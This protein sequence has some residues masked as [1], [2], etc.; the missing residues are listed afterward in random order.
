MKKLNSKILIVAAAMLLVA[1][2]GKSEK[3]EEVIRPVKVVIAG[4]D[5]ATEDIVFSGITVPSKETILSFKIAGPIANINL[6]Q[7]QKIKKGE[8]VAEMDTRDY[9]V[10]LEVYKKKYDAAKAA[11]DNATFQYNRAEKM[12]KGGAMSKKN[13][14]MVTAQKKAAISMLKEAEQGVANATNKLKDTQLKA[15]YDGYISKK[16]VDAGS[17][18][19][20][21]TPIAVITAEK[22]PE[23]NISIAGKDIKLLENISEAVFIP[24]DTPDKTYSLTLKEIGKNP[25]FAKITYPAVF[26]IKGGDDIRVGSS[27]KVIVKSNIDDRKEIFIPATA[28]FEDN[29]S[30]VYIFENGTA[31]AKDVKIGNLKNDGTIEILEGLKKDDKVISAGVNNIVDGEKVKLLPE[32]S[33]TNVGNIM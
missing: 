19:N 3:V 27:G 32:P 25:E 4:G 21:G 23:I 1:G 17:V 31:V 15:P 13:F 8:I 12:Y 22:A 33:K 20:A 11:S 5:Q 18:V 6:T 29:G 2:C 24:N 30:K 7:G 9:K 28:L 16:F 14:D 10:N 26:E